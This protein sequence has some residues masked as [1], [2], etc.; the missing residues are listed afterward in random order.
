MAAVNINPCF[1][2]AL[3]TGSYNTA[4]GPTGPSG[5]VLTVGPN[6]SNI[7]ISS[8]DTNQLTYGGLDT[9]HTLKVDGEFILNGVSVDKRLQKLE[10]YFG[11]IHTNSK[12]EDRW[13]DLKKLGEEYR[14]LEAHLLKKEQVWAKL[15]ND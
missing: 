13:E 6:G 10:D 14:K 2:S 1:N 3:N 8:A 12:L 11:I 7:W 9:T 4:I 5:S 15:K